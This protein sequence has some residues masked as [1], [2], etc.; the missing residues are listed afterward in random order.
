MRHEKTLV[1]GSGASALVHL[2]YNREAFALAGGQVGGLFSKA[3]DLGPQ[4]VWKTRSTTKL[5]TDMGYI[6]PTNKNPSAATRVIRVGYLWGGRIS[7]LEDLSAPDRAE[8]QR[9]Y[10]LKTRGIPPASSFMSDGKSEFD[11]YELPVEEL[12]A[13]L[14]RRVSLRIIRKSAKSVDL[15]RRVVRDSDDC[16]YEYDRLVSTVPS[17]VFL[18]LIGKEDEAPRLKAFD[19]AYEK[20]PTYYPL[21]HDLCDGKFDYAYVAG[22]EYSFHRVRRLD[23]RHVVREFT[24]KD[25]STSKFPGAAVIQK[26]GQIVSGHEVLESLPRESVRL[27]GRYSEWQHGIRLEDVAEKI[28]RGY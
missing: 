14:L 7:R 5:L 26:S 15:Y 20:A 16:P 4:Y 2:F 18:K 12:V 3:Q 13:E 23:G 24:I 27:L 28:Q 6:D 19:K 22:D 9:L 17:P 21:E 25:S 10:A 1:L 11:V 8:A